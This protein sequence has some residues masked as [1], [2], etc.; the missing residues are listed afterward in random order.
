[1][2]PGPRTQSV[3]VWR[4][5]HADLEWTTEPRTAEEK[6]CTEMYLTS[7]LQIYATLDWS[8][9]TM[10]IYRQDTGPAFI[11]VLSASQGEELSLPIHPQN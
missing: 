6:L 9:G 3:W 1:M 11:A 7:D 8:L 5:L 4:M 2:L 10:N